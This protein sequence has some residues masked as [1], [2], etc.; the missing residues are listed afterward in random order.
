MQLEQVQ[1]EEW[2]VEITDNHNLQ[3]KSNE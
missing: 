1:E 3:A 2:K